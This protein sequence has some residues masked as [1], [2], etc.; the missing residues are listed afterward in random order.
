M[1][2][3]IAVLFALIAANLS[4]WEYGLAYDMPGTQLLLSK[5]YD[6]TYRHNVQVEPGLSPY[7]EEVVYLTYL[8]RLGIGADYQFPRKIIDKD[9]PGVGDGSFS[10]LPVYV[11]NKKNI[12]L[13]PEVAEVQ[14]SLDLG[15][16]FMFAESAYLRAQDVTGGFYYSYGAGLHIWQVVV[17][18]LYKENH[19]VVFGNIPAHRIYNKA[20]C[21]SL[22][23]R[24]EKKLIA[25]QHD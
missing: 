8:S 14:L 5:S 2:I 19:G 22:G 13:I 12:L 23:W 6:N 10:F 20:W 21:I 25:P 4:A 7:V 3:Y 11:T 9:N 18:C 1:R 16:N 15:Y 24:P 17:R